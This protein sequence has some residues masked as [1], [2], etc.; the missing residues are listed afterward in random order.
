MLLWLLLLLLVAVDQIIKAVLLRRVRGRVRER[1]PKWSMRTHRTL[2]F[3]FFFTAILRSIEASIIVF[4][5]VSFI[6]ERI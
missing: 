2:F 3:F 5:A 6:R 1:G 4:T